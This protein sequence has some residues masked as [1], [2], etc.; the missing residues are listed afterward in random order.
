MNKRELRGIL[1]H[2]RRAIAPWQR[3]RAAQELRRNVARSGVLRRSRRIGFYLATGEEMNLLPLLNQASWQ[4]KACYVPVVP[5][6]FQRRLGFS[7][8]TARPRWYANR[9]GIEEHWSPRPV[10]AWQLDL[11]FLPLVGFDAEGYR[12]GM[13]GGFYDASLAYLMRRK[14]WRKP[15]LVGVGYE[16]QK[17]ERVPREPWDIPLD[18]VVTEKAWYRC[19]AS[20]SPDIS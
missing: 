7:R 1:R 8:L 19:R 2:K 17:V 10:R 16:C 6:R 18:A 20:T 3:R 14:R 4:N 9:F 5:P 15:L 11:L 13:G 12:L